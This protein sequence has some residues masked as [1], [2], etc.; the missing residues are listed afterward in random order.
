MRDSIR[1]HPAPPRRFQFGASAHGSPE[2][3]E[4]ICR[5]VETAIFRPSERALGQAHFLDPE[6]FAVRV[7][8]VLFVWTAVSDVGARDDERR[9][10]LGGARHTQ[11][12]IH[13]DRILAID[14]LY[15]PAIGFKACPTSSE[16][17]RS[18]VAD[19]V[20]EFAS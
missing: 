10:V 6:R 1:V 17:V 4:C 9:A 5:N 20:I 2:F 12:R 3:G 19:R 18:V 11:R 14:S 13:R 8:R 16:N 15:V 7:P